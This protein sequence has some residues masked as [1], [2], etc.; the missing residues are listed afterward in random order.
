V[1]FILW[2]CRQ[3]GKLLYVAY[4]SD[5]LS[6]ELA[7]RK[8]IPFCLLHFLVAS[9]TFVSLFSRRMCNSSIKVYAVN[10]LAARKSWKYKHF[11]PFW[12]AREA[13]F[14]IHFTGRLPEHYHSF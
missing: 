6:L 5:D 3:S 12:A 2:L 14:P 1:F 9:S 10:L 7:R 8:I 4:D 13:T 11:R